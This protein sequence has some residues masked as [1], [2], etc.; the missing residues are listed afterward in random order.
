M[1]ENNKNTDTL[2][3]AILEGIC[4]LFKH[5]GEDLPTAELNNFYDSLSCVYMKRNGCRSACFKILEPYAG[6][7]RE[8]VSMDKSIRDQL[9]ECI[10]EESD[11]AILNIYR[12][13]SKHVDKR[14]LEEKRVYI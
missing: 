1:L 9:W 8:R 7:F 5:F 4:G 3:K 14:A 2:T 13:V 12:V 11:R 6:L 10:G